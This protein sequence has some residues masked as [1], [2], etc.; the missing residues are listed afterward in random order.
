MKYR[1]IQD[2]GEYRAEIQQILASVFELQEYYP[3]D[4]DNFKN[5]IIK[6]TYSN[7]DSVLRKSLPPE[8]Y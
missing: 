6:I 5:C 7:L 2:D 8:Q 1:L 4:Y 3:S